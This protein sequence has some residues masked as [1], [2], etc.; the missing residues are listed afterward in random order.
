MSLRERAEFETFAELGNQ[1]PVALNGESRGAERGVDG[2]AS[3]PDF[4]QGPDVGGDT[5]IDFVSGI[6]EAEVDF[7]V[8]DDEPPAPAGLFSASQVEFDNGSWGGGE[9]G[10]ID[11]TADVPHE[12]ARIVVR[13]GEAAAGPPRAPEPE[14]FNDGPEFET[15]LGEMVFGDLAFARAPFDDAGGFEFFESLGEKRGGHQRN[16]PAEVVESRAAGDEFAKYERGP[17]FGDDLGGF[18]DRAELT[19]A[20]VR[21]H[22]FVIPRRFRF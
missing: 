14:R 22:A 19:I 4:G 10:G 6:F 21:G 3:H 1:R 18:G 11:V 16:S 2:F 15:G 17:A 20:F 8:L 9:P 12:Q 13:G 7:A 5:D